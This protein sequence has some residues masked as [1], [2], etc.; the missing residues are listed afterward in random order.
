[1]A[2]ETTTTRA[3]LARVLG[4]TEALCVV[5]G[6]VIGSGIFIV[7][8]GIAQKVPFIGGI[9]I[10]WI[11]GGLFSMAGSLT[12]AEL[13]TMLPSAGG[14]YVY[15]REAFGRLPAFLFGWTELLVIRTG[16]IATLASAFGLYFAI[17]M[18]APFGIRPLVWQTFAAVAATLTLAAINIVGTKVGGRV[19]VFGTALKVGAL[20]TMM[21]LPFALGKIDTG[22]LRP[23]WPTGWSTGIVQGM[24][25]AMVSVL[26]AYDGWVNAS[27]V[28][29]EVR[30]PSR[31]IP[32]ALILG[33]FVLIALYLGMTLVYH[34]VLPIAEIGAASTQKG[35]PRIVAADFCA[36][37]LGPAGLTAIALVVMAS[38]FI[39]L[40]GNALSGPR[41]YFAMARD[42]LFPAA[43]CRIHPRF[44][45][46]AHAIAA[47]AGWASILL[48]ATAA[49]I[50]AEP[51]T[52]GLPKPV[53][54]AW[55]KF[56]V[57][58]LYDVMLTYVIFGGTVFY[59]LSI[60]SVFVLRARRP[61]LPR[62]YRTWGYPFTPLLYVVSA[63]LLLGNMLVETPTE[64]LAGLA[65]VAVGIP[66]YFLFSAG[67]R[68]EA[69]SSYD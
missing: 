61:D 46:P 20:A 10:V 58:P 56:H 25:A 54:D 13:G 43:L 69:A 33:M 60:A 64:S 41:A 5:V 44:Q 52:A 57:T 42:G 39:S 19:Q 17:L 47:Q 68:R 34:L 2:T 14:P 38:T 48:V 21:V 9:A 65:I 53:L 36:Y 59:T 27:A 26:W 50:L 16:S 29:E 62:P 18:P 37:L 22:L 23:M 45:T 40:N 49:L 15:L 3:T 8:A 28:A 31:N 6:S 51:P 35:S 32:R 24:A 12:L 1:M 30:D 67:A 55:E 11:V 4:P 63:L 7:P 66:A